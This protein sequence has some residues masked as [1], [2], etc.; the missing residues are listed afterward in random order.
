[1]LYVTLVSEDRKCDATPSSYLPLKVLS[2]RL[3]R[4]GSYVVGAHR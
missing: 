3:L 4:L 1:M 2:S